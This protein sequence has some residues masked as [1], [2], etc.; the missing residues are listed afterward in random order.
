MP[1][2]I[3]LFTV[4]V[5]SP[6][7]TRDE[8]DCLAGVVDDLN[9]QMAS[10]LDLLLEL[11]R[12]EDALPQS[13]TQDRAS[14]P[15]K[16]NDVFVGILKNRLGTPLPPSFGSLTGTEYEF[17]LAL[18]SFRRTGVPHIL[19]YASSRPVAGGSIDVLD[20]QRR[21][22]EFKR[23]LK[24]DVPFREFR[25]GREFARQVY[26][27]IAQF[28]ASWASRRKLH[29]PDTPSVFISYSREDAELIAS[30]ASQLAVGGIRTW[31][32]TSQLSGGDDW[33]TKRA[34]RNLLTA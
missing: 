8:R 28:L 20:Q 6:G 10:K 3:T 33:I 17:K 23:S 9:R 29:A 24:A 13:V 27:D 25:D 5:S 7:D 30:L 26:Q 19:V 12:W 34:S 1:K 14:A 31:Y 18:D 15:L 11:Q 4:W 2:T 16:E 22:D 32:D 21:V